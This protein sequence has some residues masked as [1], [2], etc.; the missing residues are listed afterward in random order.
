MPAGTSRLRLT[1]MASHTAAELRTAARVLGEAARK[2]GLNPEAMAPGLVER[3]LELERERALI[4][5]PSPSASPYERE[6]EV[7]SAAPAAADLPFERRPVRPRAGRRACRGAAEAEAP[8]P[9]AS[10]PFDFER[11]F[12]GARAA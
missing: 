1:V 12:S 6:G 2:L 7:L 11:E 10:A 4:S 3:Q 5:R 8:A 9:P